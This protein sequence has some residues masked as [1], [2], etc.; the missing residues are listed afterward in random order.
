VLSFLTILIMW[1]NHHK[2]FRQ[3]ERS[4]GALLLL[5]GL[6]LLS[7]TFLPFPTALLSEYANT[8]HGESAAIVYTGTCLAIAVLFNFLWH[9]AKRSN[10][11]LARDH[12]R[13]LV[14][15]I[16]RQYRIGAFLYLLAFGLAFVTVLA[17]ISLCGLLTI[18]FALPETKRG[19]SSAE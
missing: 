5:N 14:R 18:F 10:R 8:V 2:L 17:S 15:T 9:H 7:I 16:T 6:L 13:V 4:D 19:S 1:M 11:L 12:D 3:I